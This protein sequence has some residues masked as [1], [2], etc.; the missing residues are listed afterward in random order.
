M[1]KALLSQA[2]DT[3]TR[4]EEIKTPDL[5]RDLIERFLDYYGEWAFNRDRFCASLLADQA[6][7]L[8]IGAFIR[9]F[10]LRVA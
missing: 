6:Q 9:T 5:K 8:D 2:A 7:V 3:D 4:Y 10:S 1:T